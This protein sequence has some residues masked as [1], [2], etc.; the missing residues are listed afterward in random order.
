M[1]TA[2]STRN[3]ALVGAAAL[4]PTLAIW[5]LLAHF[6]TADLGFMFAGLGIY[7]IAVLAVVARSRRRLWWALGITVAALAVEGFVLSIA[8]ETDMGLQT[9]TAVLIPIAYVAAWGIARRR[10]PLWWKVGLPLA[11]ISV[12]IPLSAWALYL[13]GSGHTSAAMF[14]LLWPG[15]VALGSLVCW[16]AD[17]RAAR[18]HS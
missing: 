6:G 14:W 13:I 16:A 7:F 18:V 8:G 15:V 17:A 12:I 11:A 1:N 4:A 10:N 3:Q 5:P 2:A 9:A